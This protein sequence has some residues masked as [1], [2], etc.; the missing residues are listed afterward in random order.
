MKFEALPIEGA[1]LVSM[2]P[3]GDD[4]GYF[5]RV[6]CRHEVEAHGINPEVA[7]IN[8]SRSAQAG[9][10][11][12]LHWQ[13]APAEETKLFRCLSGSVYDVMVDMRPDSASY[14]QHYGV[15]LRA[16][17]LRMVFVPRGCAHGFMTLA[18]DTEVEYLVSEFYAG[19]LEDG[20]RH[21]DP[22]FDIRWPRE[23]V[24]VSDKDRSWPLFSERNP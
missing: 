12:G 8:C 19:E 17:D 3:R 20:L 10:M 5:A 23:A 18:D 14:L 9:T 22:Y 6:F 11:R 7:Q 1:W 2:E 15:E 24:V 13:K 21:D 16:G 4:R